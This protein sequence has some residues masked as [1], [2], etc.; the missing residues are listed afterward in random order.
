MAP[1]PLEEL[2]NL[3]PALLVGVVRQDQ[4]S[5]RFEI[6]DWQVEPLSDQGI[7]N[8]EG[9]FRVCGHGRDAAG[10]RPWTVVVKIVKDPGQ[11]RDPA[12]LWYWKRETLLAQSGLLDALP[13]PVCAP[14]FYGVIE[15]ERDDWL[16]IEYIADAVRGPWGLEGY[17]FAARQFGRFNAACAQS[18]LPDAPWLCRAHARGWA[19]GLSPLKA[20]ENPYVQRFFAAELQTRAGRLWAERERFYDALARLPQVFSHFD[21]QRR[22][23]HTRRDAAGATEIIAIDWALCGIGPL[24]G[25]LYALIGSSAALCEWEPARLE[26]IEAAVYAAYLAGLAE[27]GWRGDPRL[28]RLGYTAWIALHWG[29]ALPAASAFWLTESMIPHAQR[30][31]GHSPE[32]LALGWAA[33]CNFSLNRGDEA[34]GL[35]E[36]G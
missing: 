34:R 12:H 36:E 17:V 31:F 28:P 20:W 6:T 8:P 24:G 21:A 10:A 15:R 14:R 3:D 22:N 2:R 25:D 7:I 19:E 32:E 26:E 30:R 18:P 29:L 1:N 35:R 23:L 33:L 9:L 13:G 4:R 27:G 16:W 5:P 11:P